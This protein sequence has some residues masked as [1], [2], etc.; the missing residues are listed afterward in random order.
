M[1]NSVEELLH[2][3]NDEYQLWYEA[4]SSMKLKGE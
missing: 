1:S 3:S 2:E 4:I